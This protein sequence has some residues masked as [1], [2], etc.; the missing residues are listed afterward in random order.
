MAVWLRQRGSC[1][2]NGHIAGLSP[3]AVLGRGYA[4]VTNL[5]AKKLYH[6]LNCFRRDMDKSFFQDGSADC[7]VH[8]IKKENWLNNQH[9]DK[10]ISELTFEQAKK[11]LEDI[12]TA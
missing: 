7:S 8:K 6:L 5:P 12:V 3:L 11:E 10:P 2:Q 1:F 4:L 9:T